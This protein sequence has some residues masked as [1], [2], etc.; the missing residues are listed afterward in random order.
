MSQAYAST[1]A[2]SPLRRLGLRLWHDDNRS[3]SIGLAAV[4]VFHLLLFLLAPIF[5]RIEHIPSAPRPHSTAREFNIELA[6]EMFAKAPPKPKDPFK[7]VETNPEAPENTPDKTNNFAAQNQQAAQEKPNP[8][9]KSDRAA[10]QGKK[11]TES[12]QIVSGRLTQPTERAEPEPPP[13]PQPTEATP[14]VTPRMQ[15]NPLSGV[16]KFEGTNEAGIGG[17]IA[18]RLE[19]AKPVTEKV[20]GVKDA[21]ELDGSPTMPVQQQPAIDPRRPRP[22]PMVVKQQQVRPAILA[23][24]PVGTRNMGISGIDARWSNYGAYLQ[25]M[26]D[27]VQIQWERLILS[28]SAMPASG[29]TV[30]VRFVINDEGKITQIK[31]VETAASETASRACVSAITDRSPYGAWTDDMKAMLG[32]QQEMTFTFFYQ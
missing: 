32:S 20:E 29:S 6:P 3:T 28:M 21:K 25:R 10:T 22:R 17:S 19:N 16:E 1:A 26:V 13:P 8:D 2:T 4:V 31:N 12:N 11:E 30:S 27:T 14:Q 18:K 15:Q 9:G 24:N 7:F 5:L 23:D